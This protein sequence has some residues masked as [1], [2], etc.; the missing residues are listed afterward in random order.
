MRTEICSPRT[1]IM[2]V[3]AD[4]EKENF[5]IMQGTKAGSEGV[6]E[7]GGGGTGIESK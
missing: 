2:V 1:G 7:K 5:G 3:T 4:L 6:Q